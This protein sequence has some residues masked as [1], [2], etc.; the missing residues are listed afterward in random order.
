ML[1]YEKEK[2]DLILQ[3]KT[4]TSKLQGMQTSAGEGL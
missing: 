1:P 4:I 2:V 3:M